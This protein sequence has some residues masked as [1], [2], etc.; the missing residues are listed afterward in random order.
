[1]ASNK[2]KQQVDAIL[3]SAIESYQGGKVSRAIDLLA[4]RA[5]GFKSPKVWGYLGFLY[6][7]ARN[8]E[9]AVHAFRKAIALA[10]RS[11]MASLGLFHSLW[12]TDHT[13]AAFDEM[14]RFLKSNDSAHYRQFLRDMLADAPRRPRR[15]DEPLAAA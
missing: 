6:T 12:R 5:T 13:D 8:D 3:K 2:A 11:E 15:A 14:R 10:P 4:D 7:E 9:K 1:M